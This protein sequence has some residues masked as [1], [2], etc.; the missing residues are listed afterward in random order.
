MVGR[1]LMFFQQIQHTMQYSDR[2]GYLSPFSLHS[3]S[4]NLISQKFSDSAVIVAISVS[5]RC[6]L[7]LS[8]VKAQGSIAGFLFSLPFCHSTKSF[9]DHFVTARVDFGIA[10]SIKFL[11]SSAFIGFR[12]ALEQ[13]AMSSS[14]SRRKYKTRVR[15]DFLAYNLIPNVFL[16][17]MLISNVHKSIIVMNS[18]DARFS[19]FPM[20][21]RVKNHSATPR[22][23]KPDKT[24]LLV[25]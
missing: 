9:T 13:D 19:T 24:L 3:S 17:R 23:F 12:K 16:R 18:L 22:G 11:S 6:T 21:Y 4:T 2:A 20:F 7:D 25:F 1:Y 5:R 14:V 10:F 8:V 15:F